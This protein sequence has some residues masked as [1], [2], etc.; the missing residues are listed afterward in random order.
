MIELFVQGRVDGMF[1]PLNETEDYG[2]FLTNQ[3]LPQC[4][5]IQQLIT[6]CH[7][8]N[9]ASLASRRMFEFFFFC[10][11]LC[12]NSMIKL[13]KSKWIGYSQGESKEETM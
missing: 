1:C 7:G 9:K 4:F 2:V 8:I 13:W 3:T 6:I 11:N 10:F 5:Q 12:K